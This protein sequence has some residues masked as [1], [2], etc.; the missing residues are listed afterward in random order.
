M[1]QPIRRVDLG[2]DDGVVSQRWSDNRVALR[3]QGRD[4]RCQC[5]EE[6]TH[7][8]TVA[9]S[10]LSAGEIWVGTDDGNIQLT[11]D[12]GRNWTNLTSKLVGHPGY[13]VSRIVASVHTPGTAFVT[14]TGYRR[15]DHRP[16]IWKTTDYG[17]TWASI[18]GNLPSNAINPPT[19][20]GTPIR[21]S[22]PA[23]PLRPTAR[24]KRGTQVP[25]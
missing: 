9:G 14:I 5:I 12:G 1:W 8:R 25:A 2:Q 22:S 16:F 13:W 3:A 19:L 15:D 7:P 21:C 4:Q 17:E 18:A 24:V 11:R 20:P 23:K 10:A 6:D